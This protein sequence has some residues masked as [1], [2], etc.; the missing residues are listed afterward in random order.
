MEGVSANLFLQ[1][2]HTA[3]SKTLGPFE[4]IYYTE[5]TVNET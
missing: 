5:L 2:H 3:I 4:Q 1:H